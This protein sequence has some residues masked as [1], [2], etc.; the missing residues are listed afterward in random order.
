MELQKKNLVM[1]ND[2]TKLIYQ[3]FNV[4]EPEFCDELIQIFDS[5][6]KKI[7]KSH[8]GYPNFTEVNLN[9]YSKKISKQVKK[10]A[11]EYYRS[12]CDSIYPLYNL[13]YGSSDYELERVRIKRYLSNSDDRFDK[14]HDVACIN[15]STRFLSFLFYLNDDFTGGETVFYPNQVV[16]PIKGSVLIFPP[17]WMFP[18]SGEKVKDGTKYI[19]ST[20]LSWRYK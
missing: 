17:Y 8:G 7:K 15:S 13:Y 11:T 12:Y 2:H 19:M 20:Y 3:F 9:R 5:S 18:H 16:T 10:I 4:L 1:E 14:H 6:N